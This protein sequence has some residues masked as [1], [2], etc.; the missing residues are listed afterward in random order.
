MRCSNCG[1]DNDGGDL[2]V[3]K[4]TDQ[5]PAISSSFDHS[6]KMSPPSVVR[7]RGDALEAHVVF[8]K[9]EGDS[10]MVTAKLRTTLQDKQS[11][12]AIN[13]VERILNATV[14][15]APYRDMVLSGIQG[16]L[17]PLHAGK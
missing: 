11:S 15:P 17:F 8:L 5:E 2:Y 6:M 16:H 4:L 12:C 10:T 14:R 13:L 1:T 9:L 7:L 3:A